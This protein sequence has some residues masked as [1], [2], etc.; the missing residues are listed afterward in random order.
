MSAGDWTALW[1][2][3]QLATITTVILII[4]ATPL[5]WWLARTTHP[6]RTLVEPLVALPIVLPPTVLGFYL[7]LAFSPSSPF[8]QLW[9]NIT[10]HTLAF[11]F[12]ALV[13]GSVIY[14]LPFYVQPLQVVFENVE[15]SL[16]D[17]AATLGSNNLDRFF[18]IIIPLSRRGF[19]VAI[20]LAFAHTVGEFGIVLMIGGNIPGETRVLSITLF[21]HVESLQ[22]GQAHILAGGLLTFSF[23]LLTLVYGVNRKW[24]NR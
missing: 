11:S 17:A 10:D 9:L 18:A 21:D 19:V 23:L 13:I 5:A 6:I 16:L 8:G 14:S 20:C 22:Y 12:P 4:T 15:Q 3:A 24:Q 1:V 7:L 2:T